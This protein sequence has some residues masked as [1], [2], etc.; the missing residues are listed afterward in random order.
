LLNVFDIFDDTHGYVFP[1]RDA[2]EIFNCDWFI[3]NHGKFDFF[4]F[5]DEFIYFTE[6][7]FFFRFCLRYVHGKKKECSMD[8]CLPFERMSLSAG[9]SALKNRV[10]F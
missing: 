5:L 8:I 3:T 2:S 7:F 4:V 6:R 9:F 10:S 1:I